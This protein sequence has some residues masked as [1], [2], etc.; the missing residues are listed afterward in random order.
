MI[1]STS[2]CREVKVLWVL[3]TGVLCLFTPI[4]SLGAQDEQPCA[5]EKNFAKVGYLLEKKDY[6]G[7]KVLLRR[8]EACPHLSAVQRFNVGWLYGKAHDFPDALKIFKSVQPNVP[9]RL[10]H[11]YA[12]ALVHFD[13]GHYQAAIDTLTAL[14][15]KG[16]FDPK[17][18]DLL[19]VAYSK[20]GRYQE[21]YA[22]MV[23][24]LRQH[25]SNPYAYY[26]LITLFVDTGELDKAAQVADKA[27][28]ALPQNAEALSMRG[29]I[30]LSQSKTK[31][32]YRDF[33]HAAQLA[34]MAPD[35]PF[36]MALADYRQS[37]FEEA[38][39][40]LK[41][42]IASGIV[43]SDLHYLFAE[44]LIR[45][46]SLHSATVLSELDRA[47]ELN[48]NSVSARV[49]RG[50]ILLKTGHPQDAIA[51]LKIAR[52]LEPNPQRDA[53]NATYLL[54]R[55]YVAIGKQDE[56]KVLFAQ[57]SSQFSS[58]K[59]DTLNRLSDLKMH[60]V[61]HR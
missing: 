47:I 58:D 32:A 56:A 52:K 14:R 2:Q 7:A 59:A 49:L 22:V 34:P 35:P 10:T 15:S 51:D 37:K 11:A 28:A 21:A 45:I 17:C 25:P 19:G 36:F 26:N 3:L 30:E 8:L 23:E 16:T 39:Q 12:V 42:A 43:D 44:C 31:D 6:Q 46:D 60:A 48:P 20:L 38:I 1:S 40:V 54:A 9:D 29:S 55:A 13:Q 50:E 4:V 27:V 53:R 57:V 18:A 41:N 24:N 5:P 33:A 61:L